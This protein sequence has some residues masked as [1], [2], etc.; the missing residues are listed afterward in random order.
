LDEEET[1]H[2][3][4]GQQRWEGLRGEA[5][6]TKGL[7]LASGGSKYN[8]KAR[9]ELKLLIIGGSLDLESGGPIMVGGMEEGNNSFRHRTIKESI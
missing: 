2:G 6:K 9:E 1:R 8:N 4:K 3:E 7:F 5:R